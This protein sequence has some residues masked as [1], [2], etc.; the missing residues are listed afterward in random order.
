MTH[1]GRFA[2]RR[3]CRVA[4]RRTMTRGVRNSEGKETVM[5]VL[6]SNIRAAGRGLVGLTMVVALM[7]F[8]A[9]CGSDDSAGGGTVQPSYAEAPCPDPV[10]PDIVLGPEYTCGYLTVPENRS[11]SDGRTIRLAVATRRATE[12]NPKPDPIVFLTGGPGGSGLGEGP[13]LVKEWRRDRDV[14]LLDQR[15]ALQS[16]PFLSCPETDAF[17]ESAVGLS[18]LAPETIRQEAAT[19]RACRDRLVATGADLAAYNT[20][21][22]SADVADLRIAMGYEEW[23]VYGVSY[24]SDL[25]LQTLRD[26]PAGI[27][28]VVVD[29]VVPPNI[30][31]IETGW[32][33]ARESA[34]AIYDACA[35]QPACAA[36]FPDGFGEYVQVIKDLAANPR[37][38]QVVDPKTGQEV[39]VVIDAYKLS[40]LVQFGT[41]IGSP[42]RIPLMIHDLA[43]G[44]GTEA[45]REVLRG[46][47]PRD[48]NSYGLQWGVLC[49]E[50]VGRTDP[51]RVSAAGQREL[52]EFPTSVTDRPAVFPWAFDD[53]AEWDVPAAP[54]QVVRVVTSDVPVLLTSGSFDGT[55]PPSYADEQAKTLKNSTHLVF[56]GVGHAVAR[57]SPTCFA[58]IMANFLDQPSDF[59]YSCLTKQTVPN[60]DTH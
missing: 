31:V 35:A 14:I 33:A 1:I 27:R 51:E 50:M 20:T 54:A 13:G 38:V 11:K 39:T 15:G 42:P 29:A 2:G 40:Y 37:T 53:C 49:R 7:L 16:D 60:F 3:A 55:A 26:H 4:A 32:R 46:V 19:T 47:F 44:D 12:P 59:D 30:D 10:Y 8:A 28:S 48:F 57:W 25:A 43:V 22:S 23:N 9:A 6:W 24:G 45:A 41:L 5:R 17:L 34:T 56:P 58:I 52:P 18:W 21:E 36:A